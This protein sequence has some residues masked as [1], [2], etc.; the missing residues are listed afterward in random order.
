MI[1]LHQSVPTTTTTINTSTTSNSSN[2]TTQQQTFITFQQAL[3]ICLQ[4]CNTNTNFEFLPI[5][6]SCS[7]VCFKSIYALDP[8][9][10]WK[11]SIKDGI[12]FQFQATPDNNNQTTINNNL[13]LPPT[14]WLLTANKSPAG[15]TSNLSSLN[16]SHQ[17]AILIATGGVLPEGCD[18]VIEKEKLIFIPN[19]NLVQVIPGTKWKRGQ[20]VR[21]IGSDIQQNELLVDQ[22]KIIEP[23]DIALLASAGI[24][25]IQV[26]FK[27]KIAILSTGDELMDVSSLSENNHRPRGLIYDSNRPLLISMA[28]K[29]EH[30]GCNVI[31]YGIVPDSPQEIRSKFIQAIT[32][33]E[34]IDILITSGG[35]SVGERDF[36]RPICEELGQVHFDLVH[37][38][39]GKPLTFATIPRHHQQQQI[40][41]TPNNPLFVFA[42]PGNPVSCLVTFNMIVSPVCRGLAGWNVSLLT[43]RGIWVKTTHDIILDER[44]EF[45]RANLSSG[46]NNIP[47]A[48][49]TCINNQRSSRLITTVNADL[50]LQLPGSK[51]TTH[52]GILPTGS[53][54]L[55]VV[56]SDLRWSRNLPLV[57]YTANNKSIS[58][59]LLILVN[60]TNQQ[61]FSEL[62][63]QF[64][65]SN[66]NNKIEII[67]CNDWASV[68]EQIQQP[69]NS[70]SNLC[71]IA[72][73]Y[74]KSCWC[75]MDNSVKDF[76]HQQ[77][78]STHH[79][80]LLPQVGEYVRSHHT[81]NNSNDNMDDSILFDSLTCGVLLSQENNNQCFLLDVSEVIFSPTMNST[82]TTTAQKLLSRI[83]IVQHV[84]LNL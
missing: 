60:N 21:E 58:K 59:T 48:T 80:K 1:P 12:A 64:A 67:Q 75:D 43:S 27:P 53:D 36:V 72:L 50:L 57:E 39:P 81:D 56:L 15:N 19:T 78:S 63:E 32:S 31:D 4:Y 51:Q 33:D 52:N 54:V 28:S 5:T 20:D 83:S 76:I 70:T 62:Q 34:N 44:P 29:P 13:L 37:V 17:E 40:S 41:T 3:T 42:L 24:S 30:G 55:G 25:H 49:V 77:I 74:P 23:W 79:G 71:L 68:Q 8:V 73:W 2:S 22:G 16:L 84:I 66:N 18:T 47:M 45:Q 35:V 26:F 46:K 11:T 14:T 61:F 82:P 7:R 10:K 9:P 38:K 65:L 69:E 6:Q